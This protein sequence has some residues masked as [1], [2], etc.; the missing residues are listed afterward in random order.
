MV[1][2]MLECTEQWN[3][4]VPATENTRLRVPPPPLMLP[5]IAHDPSSSAAEWGTESL[6]VHVI[7]SPALAVT[8]AQVNPSTVALTVVASVDSAHGAAAAVP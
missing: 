4:K 5:A 2:F 6:F 8:G 7:T 1:P 3:G